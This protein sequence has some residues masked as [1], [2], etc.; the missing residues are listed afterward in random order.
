MTAPR[1]ISVITEESVDIDF[2]FLDYLTRRWSAELDVSVESTVASG[3]RELRHR[4]EA[5]WGSGDPV[6]VNPGDVDLPG[7]LGRDRQRTATVRIELR[8]DMNGLS[9]QRSDIFDW[10]ITG[11]GVDGYRWAVLKAM[12]DTIWPA[13]RYEYSSI[14]WDNSC[15]L[16]LPRAIDASTPICVVI[17]GGAWRRHWRR[18][19]MDSL[20]ID[21]AR[22]GVATWN[23]GYRRSGP[24]T[25]WPE[26]SGDVL[27]AVNSLASVAEDRGLGT[28]NV[29]LLGHSAGA[30]LALWLAATRHRLDPR[31]ALSGAVSLAGV[32]DLVEHAER[33][34]H[35][36]AALELMGAA[37]AAIPDVYEEASPLLRLPIG[38]PIW[39]FQGLVDNGDLVDMNRR[40]VSAAR[41]LGDQAALIEV[42]DGNHFDVIDPRTESWRRICKRMG[43]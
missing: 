6:V 23:I 43:W 10:V 34:T 26:V 18:D 22:R 28:D 11:R 16:R 2:A 13:Q 32:T 25:H 1:G 24:D 29:V 3:E 30:Q 33:G 8:R 42:E 27:D 17:H 7:L 35:D 15:D 36:L 40:F 38:V 20:C 39:C 37:P 19:I 31:L 12:N 9:E 41:D 5:A 4:V 21:L 14:S